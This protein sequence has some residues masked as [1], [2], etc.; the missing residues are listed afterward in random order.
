[1]GLVAMPQ[2]PYFDHCA[3]HAARPL[4]TSEG[5]P[6]DRVGR[7]PAHFALDGI[8]FKGRQVII[9]AT[10]LISRDAVS[11]CHHPWGLGD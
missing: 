10:T 9:R 1:M 2:K 11:W 6:D 8:D 4:P 5:N 3:I 7:L